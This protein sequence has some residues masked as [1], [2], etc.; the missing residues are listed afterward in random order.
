MIVGVPKEIKNREFRVAMTPEGVRELVSRGHSVLVQQSAG[1]GAGFEDADYTKVGANLAADAAEVFK[2]ADL[3]V[4]VKEPQP[5]ETQLLRPGQTLFT[6]LHLAADA[7]LTA[8]LL[9]SGASAI[10][11]EAVTDA[12]GTLPLLSPMSE[13]AGRL[14]IQEGAR[15]LEKHQGGKGMLLGGVPG[16]APANVLVIG[17][18]VVGLNAARVAMGMGADVT[19][20]DRSLARLRHLDDLYGDRLRTLYSSQETLERQLA[21]AD[22]VV[23]AVLIPG[24]AAPRL[25]TRRMLKGMQKG[26]VMVDVAIDQGGC[27]ES[28]RPTTHE[29]PTFEEEGIVHYCVTNMPGAVP[30]TSTVALANAT[31]PFVLALANKGLHKALLDDRHLCN[32]LSVHAGKL[33]SAAVAESL[34]LSVS[35][36]TDALRG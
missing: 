5:E 15:F 19:V 20:L 11:Y 34:G 4:K 29:S 21:R 33:T 1:L 30:R 3:V 24:A 7:D 18:G 27:F 17:A 35:D 32:G 22:L 28:S 31:L 8:R 14:S 16:V 26:T 12:Q 36:A 13:V 25:V 10:A 9:S 23:G 2:R 6:Y